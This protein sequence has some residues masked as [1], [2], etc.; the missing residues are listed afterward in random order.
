MRLRWPVGLGTL[1]RLNASGESR[2]RAIPGRRK[3]QG[4]PQ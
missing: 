3:I 4:G 2:Y 1:E